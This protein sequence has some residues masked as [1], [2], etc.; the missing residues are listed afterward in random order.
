MFSEVRFTA[1][2]PRL[3]RGKRRTQ[4]KAKDLTRRTQRKAEGTEETGEVI[5]PKSRREILRCAQ[6]DGTVYSGAVLIARRIGEGEGDCAG[7]IR[8]VG[9]WR[10]GSLGVGGL[11][12]GADHGGDFLNVGIDA[13]WDG[14]GGLVVAL[15]GALWV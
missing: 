13:G 14:A 10:I 4:R 8:C 6:D 15:A 5:K 1:E 9:G 12:A 2:T 11:I 3:R 7:I